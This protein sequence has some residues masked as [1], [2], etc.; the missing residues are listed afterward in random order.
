MKTR[1]AKKNFKQTIL[2]TNKVQSWAKNNS[3]CFEKEQKC[4]NIYK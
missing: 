3:K 1:K 4:I 2:K